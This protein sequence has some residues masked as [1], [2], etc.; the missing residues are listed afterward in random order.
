MNPSPLRAELLRAESQ[1]TTASAAAALPPTAAAESAPALTKRGSDETLNEPE[2]VPDAHRITIIDYATQA[3]APPAPE[4]G[5]LRKGKEPEHLPVAVSDVPVPPAQPEWAHHVDG[6]RV[7]AA[8]LVFSGNF[9]EAAY[10]YDDSS[11]LLRIFRDTQM[12]ITLFFAIS[13]RVLT[14]RMK[15]D[16]TIHW[17]YLARSMFSR[18]FRFLV[19]A[20]CI[21]SV[22]WGLAASGYLSVSPG[23]LALFPPAA[24]L[25]GAPK[26]AE[27]GNFSKLFYFLNGL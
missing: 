18:L 17:N 9:F 16:K 3:M 20:L 27:I 8:L 6:L 1:R 24:G 7:V 23:V 5:A 10:G 13:G 25:R 11:S 2:P 19:P 14:E 15:F 12:G 22:Q 21:A 4:A 26:W